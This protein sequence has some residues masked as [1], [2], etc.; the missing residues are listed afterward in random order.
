VR[1]GEGR[2]A[3]SYFS[4]SF[5]SRIPVAIMALVAVGCVSHST[6]RPA[7]GA[8]SSP[9]TQT[10]A[11]SPVFTPGIQSGITAPSGFVATTE[12]QGLAGANHLVQI[13]AGT[14]QDRPAKAHC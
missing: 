13:W 6:T 9:R 8:S 3:A 12:W 4:M 11:S 10:G 2:I 1:S 14:P 5:R 7:P